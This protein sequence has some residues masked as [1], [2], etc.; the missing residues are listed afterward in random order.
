MGEPLAVHGVGEK[1][2][3]HP[4]GIFVQP[5]LS[6]LPSVEIPEQ[7]DVLRPRQPLAEPPAA[8]RPV[9]LPAEVTVAVGVVRDRAGAPA[10]LAQ[11]LQVKVVPV[12]DLPGGGLQPLVGE[13]CKGCLLYTSRCV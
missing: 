10:D 9:A 3:P 7:I 6:A 4:V 8:Q 11:G 1:G 5:Q 2:A 13:D 12:A